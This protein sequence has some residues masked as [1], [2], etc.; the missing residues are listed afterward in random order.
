MASYSYSSYDL[1][2]F[3]KGIEKYSGDLGSLARFEQMQSDSVSMAEFASH[4]MLS[5]LRRQVSLH[6]YLFH[7]SL[8][9]VCLS[10]TAKMVRSQRV[11]TFQASVLDILGKVCHI[12]HEGP[13][14]CGKKE[15]SRDPAVIIKCT[16]AINHP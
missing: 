4:S 6:I 7:E 10:P 15:Q 12:R 14:T 5:I 16:L 2:F 3:T 13:N 8:N 11:T 9:Q 1:A